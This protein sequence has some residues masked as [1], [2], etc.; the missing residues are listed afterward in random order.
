MQ[1]KRRPKRTKSEKRQLRGD[2]MSIESWTS[3]GVVWG[4]YDQTNKKK[5]MTMIKK[6]KKQSQK[7]TWR[8]RRLCQQRG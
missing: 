2:A 4:H 6:K 1:K 7:K 8:V 3:L 5:K